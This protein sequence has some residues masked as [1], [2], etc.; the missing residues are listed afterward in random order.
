MPRPFRWNQMRL[1]IDLAKNGL[2][3]RRQP[4]GQHLAAI[5]AGRDVGHGAAHELRRHHLAGARLRHLAGAVA[6]D[7]LGARPS[8]GWR[9]GSH[10]DPASAAR[11]RRTRPC[12]SSRPASSARTDGCGTWRTACGCRRRAGPSSRPGSVGSRD[13]AVVVGRRVGEGAAVG[14]QQ[15]AHHL[16]ER[17]VVVDVVAQPCLVDVRALDLDRLAVAAEHVGPFQRP[18]VGVLGPF[19]QLVDQLRPLVRRP[20]R[21]GTP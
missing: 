18:E 19:Q 15:L 10:A 16:V 20:C 3:G 9:A 7:D 4:V 8:A 1:T 21:P 11:G 5:L 14:R 6:V 13:D 12:C 2:S 17:R